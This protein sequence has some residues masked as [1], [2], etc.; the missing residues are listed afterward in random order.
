VL[1]LFFGQR[2]GTSGVIFAKQDFNTQEKLLPN[3]SLFL[4]IF[5]FFFLENV[6]HASIRSL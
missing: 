3:F 5:F 2:Q 1:F 6:G 4:L